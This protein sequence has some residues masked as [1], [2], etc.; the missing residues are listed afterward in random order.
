M[1]MLTSENLYTARHIALEL[2]FINKE[3]ALEKEVCMEG[4]TF[5]KLTGGIKEEYD[6]DSDAFI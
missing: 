1:R 3:M 5:T 4:S 2:G 6:E